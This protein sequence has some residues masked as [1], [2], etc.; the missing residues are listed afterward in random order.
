MWYTYILY[1]EKINRYYVGYTD[2][3]DRRLNQHNE[4]WGKYTKRGIPWRVEY[5]ESYDKKSEAMKRERQIKRMKSWEHIEELESDVSPSP[6]I[7]ERMTGTW[8]I[9]EKIFRSLF[10]ACSR[11]AV[12]IL[13]CVVAQRASFCQPR[14]MIAEGTF[15]NLGTIDKGVTVVRELTVK[16][17]GTDSLIISNV[18]TSCGC[19]VAKPRTTRLAPGDSTQLDVTFYTK[20]IVGSSVRRQIFVRSNDS[21]QQTLTMTLAAEIRTS[22]EVQPSYINFNVVKVGFAATRSVLLRNAGDTTVRILSVQSADSQVSVHCESTVLRPYGTASIEVKV[23]ARE[24]GKL[25]GQLEIMTDSPRQPKL[26]VSYIAR[27]QRS[28]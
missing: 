4:G 11:Y 8:T 12:T 7:R 9:V 15:F 22:I 5:S 16:N 6:E 10:S 23:I 1:S 28:N 19:T 3:V 20:D 17:T 14:I 26:L 21:T 18:S 27:V 24:R 25:L 13:L 2:D